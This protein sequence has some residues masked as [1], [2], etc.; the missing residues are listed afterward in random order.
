M[1]LEHLDKRKS[2]A[3]TDE[4]ISI[5]KDTIRNKGLR[6]TPAR[7]AV[8][9]I[10]EESQKPVDIATI[11]AEIAKHHVDADQATIYRII[12]NFLEKNLIT[13]IQ[14]N[15][16]KFFYEAKMPEHHHAICNECGKIEDISNC[17]IKRTE[18]RI[19]EKIGFVVKSHSLEF[20][21]VCSDCQK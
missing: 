21:G 18:S 5:Q 16:K 17:S 8:L 19:K 13:R 7:I 14:F 9:R 4:V 2:F 10:L 11:Y 15:K 20:F 6:V 3:Y 12:D 1:Y